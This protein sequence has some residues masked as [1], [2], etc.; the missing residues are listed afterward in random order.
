MR[1]LWQTPAGLS[2]LALATMGAATAPTQKPVGLANPASVHCGQIGGKLE[3]RKDAQG[4]ETG[5]CRL[6]DGKLCEE[7]ALFRDKKCVAP[8]E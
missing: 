3:I 1:R 6:T 7:W 4:N 5:Y 2:V 8:K